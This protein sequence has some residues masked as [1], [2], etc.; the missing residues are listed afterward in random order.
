MNVHVK[1]V[2]FLSDFNENLIYPTGFRK[3][4]RYQIS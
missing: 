2:L 1:Y 4:P 3:L